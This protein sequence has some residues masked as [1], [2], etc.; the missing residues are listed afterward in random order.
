MFTCDKHNE[1]VRNVFSLVFFTK[2]GDYMNAFSLISIWV[3][4]KLIVPYE[5]DTMRVI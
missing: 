1:M 3:D 5:L 4:I 2:R